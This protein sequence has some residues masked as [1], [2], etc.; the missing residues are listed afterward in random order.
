MALAITTN[1]EPSGVASTPSE[2]RDMGTYMARLSTG[3]RINSASDAAA[4]FASNS[5]LSAE[6]PSTDQAIHNSLDVQAQIDAAEG[7][8]KNLEHPA[9]YA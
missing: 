2:N 1:K 4:S 8:Q 9:A 5:R 6:T 3:K 7:A